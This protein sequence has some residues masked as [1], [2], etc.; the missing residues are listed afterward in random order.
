MVPE[1]RHCM[2]QPNTS[3]SSDFEIYI[4]L[5]HVNSTIESL[6]SIVNQFAESMGSDLSQRACE[7]AKIRFEKLRQ[8][9]GGHF[10]HL[11]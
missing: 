3:L 2:V 9:Q 5:K 10:E 1:L 6:K 4:Q 8:E 11:L 7:S